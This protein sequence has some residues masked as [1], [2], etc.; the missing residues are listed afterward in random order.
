MHTY[1]PQILNKLITKLQPF[2]IE[3]SFTISKWTSYSGVHK[4][5]GKIVLN[6][7]PKKIMTIG[8]RWYATLDT[9]RYFE[10]DITVPQE[11]SNRKR[12]AS[13]AMSHESGSLF[14]LFKS[15]PGRKLGRP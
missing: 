14:V 7:E 4:Q 2:V 6:K 1:N 12:T 10:A 8:D 11:L 9:T 5:P 3:K 15:S 13:R